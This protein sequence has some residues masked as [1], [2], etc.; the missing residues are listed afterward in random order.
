MREETAPELSTAR[1]AI[2]TNLETYCSPSVSKEPLTPAV[3]QIDMIGRVLLTGCW[4]FSGTS[5][6]VLNVESFSR[7]RARND[8]HPFLGS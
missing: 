4:R 7:R 2:E 3:E 5:K 8:D 6:G 1:F